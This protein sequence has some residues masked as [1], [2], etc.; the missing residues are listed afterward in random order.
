[1][2]Q[3]FTSCLSAAKQSKKVME[4]F[5]LLLLSWRKNCCH[6]IKKKT[7]ILLNYLYSYTTDTGYT[8]VYIS[9][10]FSW[11]RY[12][13]SLLLDWCAGSVTWQSQGELIDISTNTFLTVYWNSHLSLIWSGFYRNTAKILTTFLVYFS[14]STISA[15]K[16]E[17]HNKTQTM[18]GKRI[19]FC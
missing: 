13:N 6:R 15:A 16:S 18:W 7:L 1:M 11:F 14:Q 5:A 10:S 12:Q 8:I 17:W 9:R 3:S 4:A 19:S 2:N